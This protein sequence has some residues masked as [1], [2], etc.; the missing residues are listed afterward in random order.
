M[1]VYQV[2]TQTK[3]GYEWYFGVVKVFTTL[4]LAQQFVNYHQL[5]NSLYKAKLLQIDSEIDSHKAEFDE[6]ERN[7]YYLSELTSKYCDLTSNEPKYFCD[8]FVIKE[9]IIHDKF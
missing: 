4:G 6:D 2:N 7:K 1:V 8:E 3:D 5:E 9:L